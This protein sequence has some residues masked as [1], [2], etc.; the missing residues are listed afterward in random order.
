M[1]A[2]WVMKGR[3]KMRAYIFWLILHL[4]WN[5]GQDTKA[6]SIFEALRRIFSSKWNGL[7]HCHLDKRSCKDVSVWCSSSASSPLQLVLTT[8][9]SN[10]WARI[11]AEYF[12]ILLVLAER[13]LSCKTLQY[14]PP[15]FSLLSAYFLLSIH[16]NGVESKFILSQ[17]SFRK[18]SNHGNRSLTST[19]L[20]SRAGS[21]VFIGDA[22]REPV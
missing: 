2:K 3:N 13:L 18:I 14:N 16:P 6:K 11:W 19:T 12:L 4:K 9:L 15:K 8:C 20:K 7:Q 22:Q 5:V 10:H 21:L 17:S 1:F